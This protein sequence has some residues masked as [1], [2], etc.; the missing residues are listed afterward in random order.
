MR[1]RFVV[2]MTVCAFV[3]LVAVYP[4]CAQQKAFASEL[5][6]EW[7]LSLAKGSTVV[8]RIPIHFWQFESDQRK[9]LKIWTPFKDEKGPSGLGLAYFVDV[10]D[11]LNQSNWAS[12]GFPLCGN[13]TLTKI[14]EFKSP[15]KHNKLPYTEV[16]LQSGDLYLR[17]HF[18]HPNSDADAL[19]SDFQ[20]VVVA[21][22]WGQFESSEDFRKNV[23][24]VQDAKTFVGPLSRLSY[25]VK[26]A[27]LHMACDGQNTFATE[28]FKGKTYFAVTLQS[29]GKIYNANVLNS[30]ARV[31]AVINGQVVDR[32]KTFTTSEYF[33]LC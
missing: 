24:A 15:Y 21:G 32:I 27:L 11:L 4:V 28:T 25:G 1:G 10:S 16:E 20:K 12:S 31:A 13:F 29:D 18:T 6:S 33:H 5:K 30:S 26:I 3:S 17:L 22:N 14:F 23:F 9:D 2:R 19:N 8:V 7:P